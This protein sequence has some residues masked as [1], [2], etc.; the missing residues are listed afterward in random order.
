NITSS[1]MEV[2]PFKF[3]HTPKRIL[4]KEACEILKNLITSNKRSVL[5]TSRKITEPV[6]IGLARIY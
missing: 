4:K 6:L 5:K 1:F 3:H 2:V